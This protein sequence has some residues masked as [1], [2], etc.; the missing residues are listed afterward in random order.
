[1]K[2]EYYTEVTKEEAN[3]LYCHGENIYISNDKRTY[4]KLPASH[5]YGSHAPASELFCRSIPLYEG[6]TKFFVVIKGGK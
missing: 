1:M 3:D 5:D 2:N 6:E 4:W